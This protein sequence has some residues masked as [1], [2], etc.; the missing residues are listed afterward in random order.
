MPDDGR[1]G[2]SSER[3]D[4]G[5]GVR[6]RLAVLVAPLRAPTLRRL[7]I[8]FLVNELGDGISLVVLPLVVYA[9][10]RSGLATGLTFAVV[11][12]ATVVGRPLGGLL[13][14]RVD[15]HRLLRATFVVRALLLGTALVIGSDVVVVSCLVAANL[16]GSI[17][18]PSAEAAIR[19]RAGDAVQQVATIRKLS[20]AMSG[21]VGLAAGGAL[22]G[23]VG[24]PAAIATDLATFVVAL[25]VLPPGEPSA[26]GSRPPRVAPRGDWWQA[27]GRAVRVSLED[28]REGIA[29]LASH[30]DLRVTAV[31]EMAMSGL[32]ASLLTVAV[33]WLD[34]LPGAPDGAYG[35]ALAGYSAGAIAGLLVAGMIAWRV[36]VPVLAWRTFAVV[37]VVCLAGVIGSDWRMLTLSW[38]AWGIALGPLEVVMDARM[39]ART[40]QRLL[41]RTYGG[42]GTLLAAGQV[43]GALAAGLVVD[44]VG[45]RLVIVVLSAAFLVMAVGLRWWAVTAA[46]SR[47][48]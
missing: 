27:A 23:T 34:G 31:A 36:S 24:V 3:H 9:T 21:V 37:G 40:P 45:P 47:S 33:V 17:D 2:G 18:N 13:A 30:V 43:V 46:P 5:V 14:D 35:F 20:R 15:R 41:G 39:V 22:V 44:L 48:G 28:G 4:V 19:A 26:R 7:T 11:R 12:G 32:V 29:H 6:G 25:V 8:A 38:L 16:V 42:L 1:N 10:T